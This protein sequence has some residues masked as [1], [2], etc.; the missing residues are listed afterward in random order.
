MMTKPIKTGRKPKP[1]GEKV[2][3]F[4][5][6]GVTE[7]EWPQVQRVIRESGKTQSTLVRGAFGL[8]P[9]RH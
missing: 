3:H 2:S 6:A 5:G 8:P 1:K 4:V 9:A 7:R